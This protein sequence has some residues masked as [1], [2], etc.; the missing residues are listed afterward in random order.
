M[1]VWLQ[2]M[3][4]LVLGLLIMVVYRLGFMRAPADA[5]ADWKRRNVH[6]TLLFFSL[7]LSIAVAIRLY[8]HL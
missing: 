4:F 2:P 8:F 5:P 3:N 6:D 1:S 7:T